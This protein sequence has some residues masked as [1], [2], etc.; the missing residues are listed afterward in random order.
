MIGQYVVETV[1]SF[2]GLDGYNGGAD[3]LMVAPCSL[4][5]VTM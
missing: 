2:K 5:D 3:A 4:D 1:K